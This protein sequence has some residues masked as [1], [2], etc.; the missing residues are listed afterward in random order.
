MEQYVKEMSWMVM[1]WSDLAEDGDRWRAV[2]N[3]VMNV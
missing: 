3:E 1:D 2:L